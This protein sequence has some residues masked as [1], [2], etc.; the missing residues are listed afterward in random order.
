MYIMNS[1]K[2]FYNEVYK[3]IYNEVYKKFYYEDR[4]QNGKS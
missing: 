3:K 2:H 1:Y 4:F